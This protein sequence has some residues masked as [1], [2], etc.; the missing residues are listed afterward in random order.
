MTFKPFK[1]DD[2]GAFLPNE[3]SNPDE[4]F[5]MMVNSMEVHTMWGDYGD[6]RAFLCVRNYWG[7]CWTGF[8]LMATT[9]TPQNALELRELILQEMVV[10]RAVRLETLSQTNERLRKWH[11]F[12]GFTLEGTKR[13]FMFDKDYDCFAI[14]K[15]GF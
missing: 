7:R 5:P 3:F 14:V 10:R 6:V 11:E 1:I 12:L 15:E 9:F 2:L 8:I 4:I 13:K